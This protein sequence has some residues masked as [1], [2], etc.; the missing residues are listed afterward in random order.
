MSF[1]ALWISL[2]AVTQYRLQVDRPDIII[3]PQVYDIDMLDVVDVREVAKKGEA[4]VDAA[5]PQLRSLFTWRN[6]W[7]RSMGVY[8]YRSL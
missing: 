1:R 2:A 5:L 3:R 8:N 7:R 6:R 4:A